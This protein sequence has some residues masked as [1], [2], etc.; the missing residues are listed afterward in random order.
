MVNTDTWIPTLIL[1]FA[2]LKS[3]GWLPGVMHVIPSIKTHCFLPLTHWLPLLFSGISH[4]FLETAMDRPWL[5]ARSWV[6]T[7]RFSLPRNLFF[8]SWPVLSSFYKIFWPSPCVSSF[9]SPVLVLKPTLVIYLS[10]FMI[11]DD[12]EDLVSEAGNHWVWWGWCRHGLVH[13]NLSL[14][15]DKIMSH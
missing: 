4:I 5:L 12:P 8:P 6:F 1:P 13:G 10:Y 14:L 3:A 2:N 7:T 9:P 11:Q 15:F